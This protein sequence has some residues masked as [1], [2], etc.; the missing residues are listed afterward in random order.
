[1]SSL[2]SYACYLQEKSKQQK[3]HN[4]Q[5]SPSATPSESSHMKYLPKINDVP[6]VLHS[7]VTALKAVETY[8]PVAVAN[9]VPG[10]R[11]QRYR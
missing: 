2:N 10:D 8:T 4:E 6:S 11:R 1:M 9:F 7:I 3:L 5:T